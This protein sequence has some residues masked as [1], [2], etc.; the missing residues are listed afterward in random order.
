M[1]V[2]CATNTHCSTTAATPVCCNGV[3][4]ACQNDAEC[5]A[6]NTNLPACTSGTCEQ[7]NMDSHCVNVVGL[8]RC[9]NKVCVECIIDTDCAAGEI[10][11]DNLMCVVGCTDASC[12][13]MDPNS[14]CPDG[15]ACA[16]HP[17]FTEV[18]GV[19][20]APGNDLCNQAVIPAGFPNA[21]ERLPNCKRGDVS[22]Q[23]CFRVGTTGTFECRCTQ[24]SNCGAKISCAN[25]GC[26]GI[27]ELEVFFT[28]TEVMTAMQTT[29][30]CTPTFP[31]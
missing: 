12:M 10:C 4:V 27:P 22:N 16:C 6:I 9:V 15:I 1:C 25:N 29:I 30:T 13:A 28:C 17:I 11:D 24:N 18:S 8:P 26:T 19:C 5:T 31:P 20:T 14:Y 21:G 2:A 23:N 7:C 3:C